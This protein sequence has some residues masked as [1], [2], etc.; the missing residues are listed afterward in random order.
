M[1]VEDNYYQI[2]DLDSNTTFYDW[3]DKENTEIIEKLNLMSIYGVSAGNGIDVVIGTTG[4]SFDAGDAII[5][6]SET[7]PGVTVSVIL[8]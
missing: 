3:V 8:L 7:I 6:L 5:S 4:N 1:G 2:S